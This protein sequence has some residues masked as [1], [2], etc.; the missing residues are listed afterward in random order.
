MKVVVDTNVAVV[1]SARASQA[2]PE[3]VRACVRFL[4]DLLDDGVLVLDSGWHILREYMRDLRSSGQPGVGD[5]FLKWALTNR[6]NPERCESV[7][8][9]PSASRGFEEFP[10]DADLAGFDRSDRKFVAV[11]V[12]HP[13]HP[14]VANAVDSDWWHHQAALEG[15]GVRII[16][17]CPDTAPRL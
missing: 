3:R 7:P 15:N 1:A 2:S 6:T 11:A 17:L 16:Q 12:A 8:I 9:S 14:P 5:A 13:Q 4:S 10:A